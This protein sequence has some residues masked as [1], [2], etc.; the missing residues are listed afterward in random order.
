MLGFHHGRIIREL[1]PSGAI[2][3]VLVAPGCDCASFVTQDR[4]QLFRARAGVPFGRVEFV[5][6]TAPAAPEQPRHIMVW[7][8]RPGGGRRA[9][10]N[11]RET[12]AWIEQHWRSIFGTELHVITHSEHTNAYESRA[13]MMRASIVAGPHGSAFANLV[14]ARAGTMV[15]EIHPATYDA[16]RLV[17][18]CYFQLS[19][20]F[21][22]LHRVVIAQSGEGFAGEMQVDETNIVAALF[23]LYAMHLRY[24]NVAK[25]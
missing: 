5:A 19:A 24:S 7:L 20:N 6:R 22:L 3:R 17:Q 13:D 21:D 18:S 11:P 23:D 10:Q 1:P 16:H 8:A 15:L 9:V 4:A 25:W 12:I 14:L 2:N